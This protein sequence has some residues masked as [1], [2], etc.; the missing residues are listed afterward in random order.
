MNG[1]LFTHWVERQIVEC[2]CGWSRKALGHSD[3]VKKHH[4]HA[5]KAPAL[6][7]ATKPA[8]PRDPNFFTAAALGELA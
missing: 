8:V 3:A 4:D 5:A 1:H 6:A 7:L 2:T